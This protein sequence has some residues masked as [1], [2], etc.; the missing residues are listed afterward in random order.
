MMIT[1]DF[2]NDEQKQIKQKI[3]NDLMDALFSNMKQNTEKFD[4]QSASDIIFSCLV[5][6]SREVMFG[7]IIGTGDMSNADSMMGQYQM[8]VCMSVERVLNEYTS[9][10]GEV[11]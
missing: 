4:H 8:A 2:L 9:N 6:F 5:M 3:M 11:H 7:L 10:D 1:G